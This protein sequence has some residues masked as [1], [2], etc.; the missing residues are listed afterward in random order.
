MVVAALIT[1]ADLV[2]DHQVHVQQSATIN[3]G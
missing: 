1:R 2:A 3:T